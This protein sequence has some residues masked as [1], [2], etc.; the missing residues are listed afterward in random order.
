MVAA[1]ARAFEPVLIWQE[2]D[3][4]RRALA[5]LDARMRRDLGL[6]RADVEREARK[7]FWRA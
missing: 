3:K 4:Q 2:R 7:P 6:S 1:L 5:E